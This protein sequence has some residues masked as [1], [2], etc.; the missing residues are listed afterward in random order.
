M[1]IWET[2]KNKLRTNFNG[3]QNNEYK[4]SQKLNSNKSFNISNPT[5]YRT[6][7]KDENGSYANGSMDIGIT[8][9]NSTTDVHG[10]TSTCV[11][12]VK[13][14]PK[15]EVATVT[16]QGGKKDYDYRVSPSEMKDFVNAPSKGRHINK[17]W[18]YNNHI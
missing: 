13:Y 12:N 4:I 14:N 18:K 9:A 1:S 10:I 6:Y 11:K 2:I 8:N 5:S 15:K 3:T 7:H 17:V 16:F